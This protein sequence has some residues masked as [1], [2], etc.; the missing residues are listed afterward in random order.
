VPLVYAIAPNIET[1]IVLDAFWG[2]ANAFGSASVTA[3]LLD[4]SPQEL[5]GSY[6][7]VYNLAIGV[8]TFVGSLIGG[9]LS[10]FTI[11]AFGLVTG[12][13]VVYMISTVGRAIGAGLHFTLKETLKK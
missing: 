12:L 9:Y 1:L 2:I 3:Y 6:I 13:L 5:R 4:V 8:I 7:A 10:D 11:G